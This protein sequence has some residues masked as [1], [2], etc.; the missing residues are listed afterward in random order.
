MAASETR[1]F[2]VVDRLMKQAIDDWHRQ[3]AE[4]AERTC[5]PEV[6]RLTDK[7]LGKQAEL[8]ASPVWLNPPYAM[9]TEEHRRE[10]M[11]LHREPLPVVSMRAARA[12]LDEQAEQ[13]KEAI[14][15]ARARPNIFVT[16]M[17]KWPDAGGWQGTY[18]VRKQNESAEG[19]RARVAQSIRE[20]AEKAGL[21]TTQ[22]GDVVQVFGGEGPSRMA[23]KRTRPRCPDCNDTGVLAGFGFGTSPDAC[24]RPCPCSPPKDEGPSEWTVIE[25][26]VKGSTGSTWVTVDLVAA[27]GGQ[28][29]LGC[30]L[31]TDNGTHAWHGRYGSGGPLVDSACVPGEH[32][33]DM[34]IA[35]LLCGL[36]D[37]T[38]R[39]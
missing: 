10:W 8:T 7:V 38:V 20:A 21:L 18:K 16:G 11:K 24:D 1:L 33:V 2:D 3:V 19:Y 31:A 39:P 30:I 23:E 25:R 5:D 22:A 6:A 12:W 17:H 28:R 4:R 27:K 29:W 32:C 26:S 36:R 35:R 14:E 37:G 34:A 9:L 15:K 13:T